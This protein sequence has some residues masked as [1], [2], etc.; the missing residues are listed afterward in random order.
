ATMSAQPSF[1]IPNTIVGNGY[2]STLSLANVANAP[3]DMT[4][5]FGGYSRSLHMNANSATRVS[6]ADFL[7]IPGTP[8]RSDAI[9]IDS[10]QPIVAAVDIEN[11]VAVA[12]IVSRPAA[13]DVWYPN[14]V[15]GNG[16]S[17]VLSIAT[18]ATDASV[19]VDVYPSTG[20]TPHSAIITVKANQQIS[21]G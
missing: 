19:I 16:L 13:T 2:T 21:K 4:V 3:G 8:Q 9:R 15:Q 6:V 11:A 12:S 20:G 17:T 18:G 5:S 10:S 1:V 14:V 7:Q